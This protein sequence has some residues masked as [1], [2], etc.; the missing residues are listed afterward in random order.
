M[1]IFYVD[2]LPGIESNLHGIKFVLAVF[3][4]AL[5]EA[6]CGNDGGA[7]LVP[8]SVGDHSNASIR[9]R[10]GV[11]E[12]TT[13]STYIFL[14]LLLFLRPLHHICNMFFYRSISPGILRVSKRFCATSRG[15][16]VYVTFSGGIRQTLGMSY[17]N[18][19][20]QKKSHANTN[21]HT[22]QNLRY[23]LPLY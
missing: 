21:T 18:D 7:R 15:P 6:G 16:R 23:K 9:V 11:T 10:H 8:G 19:F 14:F 5:H 2:L 22:S 12:G 4:G 3:R 20:K 17:S 1:K 13:L